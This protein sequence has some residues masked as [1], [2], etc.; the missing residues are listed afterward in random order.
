M[1]ERQML[2]VD[3]REYIRY[4]NKNILSSCNFVQFLYD[5]VSIS[6]YA[7]LVQYRFW[8][9]VCSNRVKLLRT[10][11]SRIL[12]PRIENNRTRQHRLVNCDE[13]DV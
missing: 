5:F 9:F 12:L 7:I 4:C 1:I 6:K 3:G 8:V 2:Y 10:R 13:T 11:D